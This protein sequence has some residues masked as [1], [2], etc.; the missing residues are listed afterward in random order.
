MYLTK[1]FSINIKKYF[2]SGTILS[3]GEGYVRGNG[4]SSNP[5][6]ATYTHTQNGAYKWMSTHRSEKTSSYASL[7]IYN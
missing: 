6:I 4:T 7:L 1:I 2:I 3:K 5:D